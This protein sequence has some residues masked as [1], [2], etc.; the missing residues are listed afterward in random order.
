MIYPIYTEFIF[1]WYKINWIR[2]NS[3]SESMYENM[4]MNENN[5]FDDIEEFVYD[6]SYKVKFSYID[7]L[8]NI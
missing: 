3:L 7:E 5:I 6:N 4:M 1:P 8:W 2:G